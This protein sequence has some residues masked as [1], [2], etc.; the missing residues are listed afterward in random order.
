MRR[1]LI[2]LARDV[3]RTSIRAMSDQGTIENTNAPDAPNLEPHDEGMSIDDEVDE[4]FVTKME[5]HTKGGENEEDALINIIKSL[6]EECK[7]VYKSRQMKTSKTDTVLKASSD[8]VEEDS[9]PSRTLQ[10]QLQ[11]KEL[12]PGSFSLP[13]T[14]VNIMPNLVFEYLKLTNLK[15]TDTLVGMANMTQQA[16]LGT[17][18]NVLVKIDK[19]VFPCHFVVTDM[20]G[21][22]SEMIILGKPFLA[23]IHAQ[24]GVFNRDISFGIG[25]DRLKFDQN[26][27]IHTNSDIETIDSPSNIQETSESGEDCGIWPTCNPDLSFFSGYKAVYGKGVL[28]SFDIEVDYAKMFAN[29]YSRRFDEYKGI[30]INGVEQLSNEYELRIGKKGYV[31]DDVWEKC[32]QYHG[33]TTYAWHD[34]GHKKEEL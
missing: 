12:R 9:R 2:L 4:W 21:I 33:G 7:T 13:Y 27:R 11:S 30:F 19:F 23:T 31:L 16:P 28:D 10:C 24:I 6:V 15:K 14:S 8:T 22:L 26:T 34:E 5:E 29:P 1:G 32:K 25:E 20:P 3:M 18:E 17:V